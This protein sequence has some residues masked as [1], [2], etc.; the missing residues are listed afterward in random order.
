M[1]QIALFNYEEVRS[2]AFYEIS[3]LLFMLAQLARKIHSQK[4]PD[5][6]ALKVDLDKVQRESLDSSLDLDLDYIDD[7]TDRFADCWNI[8]ISEYDLLDDA[9]KMNI[10]IR[11]LKLQLPIIKEQFIK[12]DKSVEESTEISKKIGI[13]YCRESLP[14]T[15]AE[16]IK[17][18][19]DIFTRA[20]DFVEN[21]DEL[22]KIMGEINKNQDTLKRIYEANTSYY[23]YNPVV[24]NNRLPLC[25]G[26]IKCG[27]LEEASARDELINNIGSFLEEING[28]ALKIGSKT[29]EI[30][31]R[32]RCDIL[33]YSKF[34]EEDNDIVLTLIRNKEVMRRNMIIEEL[35]SK[36]GQ[37]IS[38]FAVDLAIF[39]NKVPNVSS[40][41]TT[42]VSDLSKEFAKSV[43]TV[44][45][46]RSLFSND[47]LRALFEVSEN[48][49]LNWLSGNVKPPNGFLEAYYNNNKKAMMEC[50]ERYKAK[51][52]KTKTDALNAKGVVRGISEEQI[53]REK[54]DK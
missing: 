44:N 8:V 50:A 21:V 5:I 4:L 49:I 24:D 3:N 43:K 54:L 45:L 27:R 2:P 48:T 18:L 42:S 12:L 15:F 36:L 22:E 6:L 53:Y 51:R 31:Y 37:T 13:E 11:P 30:F 52:A 17:L 20:K 46:E 16:D 35:E 47:A 39:Q 9:E 28:V 1:L 40:L 7:F 10:T 34:F 26:N 41:S 25:I 33:D 29:A 14:K 38:N 19:N 23:F 32:L